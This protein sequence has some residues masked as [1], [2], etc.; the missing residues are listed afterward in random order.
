MLQ[1]GGGAVYASSMRLHVRNCSFNNNTAKI[2]GGIYFD[3]YGI[4]QYSFLCIDTTF[5]YNE[6]HEKGGAVFIYREAEAIIVDCL[7]LHNSVKTIL[8][9]HQ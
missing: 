1:G 3:H 8:G 5:E 4:E 2:G 9:H 6:A 7:F